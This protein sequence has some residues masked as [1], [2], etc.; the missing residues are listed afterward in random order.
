[1]DTENRP[2]EAVAELMEIRDV[3]EVVGRQDHGRG[4]TILFE[5]DHG[6]S[7]RITAE[8]FIG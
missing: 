8:Q 2:T 1:M 5:P 3:A 6:L 4:S 7:E